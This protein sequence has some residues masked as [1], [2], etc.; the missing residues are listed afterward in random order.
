MKKIFLGL[1]LSVATGSA[2]A[3][4]IETAGEV[5]SIMTYSTTNTI[6]VNLS[7][8]GAPVKACSNTSTFAIP[9]S[10]SAES[11]ARMYSMV[12]AAKTA[13]TQIT[14]AYDENGGC[15]PWG[16]NTSAYRIIKRMR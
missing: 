11:R 5:T 16:S 8:Q 10:T 9:K 6:L 2:N 13:G 12:L 1:L 15:E 4:W 14:V 7:S 3:A